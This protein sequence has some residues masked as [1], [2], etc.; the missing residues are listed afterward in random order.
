MRQALSLLA[1]RPVL[2]R[3]GRAVM[4]MLAVAASSSIGVAVMITD[5]G[6]SEAFS[7]AAHGVAGHAPIQLSGPTLFGG[8]PDTV[9]TRIASVPG[10]AT[11]VPVVQALTRVDTGSGGKVVVAAFGADCR[12]KDILPSL[13]LREG[14]SQLGLNPEAPARPPT[15]PGLGPPRSG[16]GAGLAP[17]SALLQFSCS[18]YRRSQSAD[19]NGPVIGQALASK[20]GPR[21]S[22]VTGSGR[23]PLTDATAVASLDDLFGGR[24]VAFPLATAQRLFDRPGRVDAVYVRPVDGPAGAGL[25]ARIARVVGPAITVEPTAESAANNGLPPYFVPLLVLFAAVAGAVG[26]LIAALVTTLSLEERRRE[27][28]TT[29]ALGASP[30]LVR[31]TLMAPGAL[32]GLAGGALSVPI[33]LLAAQFVGSGLS[34]TT[35]QVAGVAVTDRL[36]VAAAVTGVVIGGGAGMIGALVATRRL[37]RFDVATEL[38]G[39]PGIRADGGAGPLYGAAAVA[40]GMAGLGCVFLAAKGGGTAPW[41]EPLGYAGVAVMVCGLVAGAGA[42]GGAVARPLL[43]LGPRLRGTL[44]IAVAGVARSPRHTATVAVAVA[45]VVAEAAVLGGL[46]PAIS[47]ATRSYFGPPAAGHVVVTTPPSLDQSLDHISLRELASLPGVASVGTVTRGGVHVRGVG[48]IATVARAGVGVPNRVVAGLGPPAAFRRGEV[49]VGMTLARRL[50]L[51]PGGSLILPTNN[52]PRSFRVGGVWLDALNNGVSVTLTP[53][54]FVS[55]WGQQP[56]TS[57]F[58]RPAPGV[59]PASLARTVAAA[60]LGTLTEVQTPTA[61]VDGLATQFQDQTAAFWTLQRAAVAV[62]FLAAVPVLLLA[63]RRREVEIGVLHAVGLSM[64]GGVLLS[65][66]EAVAVALG[67]AVCGI[68]FGT[69]ASVAISQMANLV[70]GLNPPLHVAWG[71]DIAYA[72]AGVVVVAGA[73]ALSTLRSPGVSPALG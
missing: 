58:L 33:G 2:R 72:A 14:E 17:P 42:I 35:E 59:S 7:Q 11:A 15:G 23:F 50:G 63:R 41:Q 21:S 48:V 49:M 38:A 71:A 52:G 61:Y 28:A 25:M 13:Q 51:R 10:V 64:R 6:A 60:H 26:A 53:S 32:L 18:P 65:L 1:V 34:S 68:V 39:I 56:A 9:L 31:A 66:T 55:A 44:R 4:T 67:A 73:A 37:R 54:A 40:I 70:L 12:I 19:P 22:I 47:A 29:M 5:S 57:I 8:V 45:A 43:G 62:L 24:V 3:P 20:L 46:Q 30:G 27:I 36:S 16:V 69:V